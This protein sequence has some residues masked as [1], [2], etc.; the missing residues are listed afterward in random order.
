MPAAINLLAVCALT[1]SVL[2]GGYRAAHA[3]AVTLPQGWQQVNTDGF[4]NSLTSGASALE[5]FRDQLYA[6][7]SNW[8]SG[9]QVWRMGADGQWLPVSE[10]GF[11]VGYANPAIADLAFFQ[12]Q[13]YAGTGWG[14][15]PGQAWRTA[16]GSHWQPVTTDGF[17]DE[18]NTVISNFA[19]FRGL[20]Y[21]GTGGT[22]GSAQIWRSRTG[23]GDGWTQ[24]APDGPGTP[25]NVTG[26]IVYK[27]ALY[28]AIESSVEGG[29]PAQVWRSFNG[30]DWT[31]VF[32]DGFGDPRNVSTGGFAELA[33]YLYLGTRND[34]TGAQI[35]RTADGQHWEKVVGDGYG[36]VSNVK[37]ESLLRYADLLYTATYNSQTGIQVWRSADGIAWEQVIAN[38]FDDSNNYAT[39]WSNATVKY[40]GKLFIGTWNTASGGE[41]WRFAP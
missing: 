7:A 22:S 34:D 6:G 2:L 29:G 5:V 20:L 1:A 21:A 17:G 30:S 18:G 4:G 38:G 8:T 16:D 28:A 10:P 27:N 25:G 32:T 23:N 36:D 15:T 35:W 39:L 26:F 33:G 19:A 12:G 11:G 40:Q 3:Q 41:V 14:D 24:V 9:G 13:L 37:V 31:V